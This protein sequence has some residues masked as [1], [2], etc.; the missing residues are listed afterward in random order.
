MANSA[1]KGKKTSG[2]S[3]WVEEF[4]K[5]KPS[6]NKKFMTTSSRPIKPLY[7]PEDIEGIDFER[8]LGYPGQYPYTRGVH[9]SMYRRKM[10]TM[11]QFSGFGSASQTNERLH[12]LLEQGQMGLSVAFF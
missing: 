9:A 6:K 8:D 7:G 1:D 2:Y 3:K 4:E 12:Y 11:R 10:W 5:S